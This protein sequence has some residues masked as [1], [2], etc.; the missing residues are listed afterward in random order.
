M[1]VTCLSRWKAD[2]EKEDGKTIF[3]LR[4]NGEL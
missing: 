1:A 4:S 3:P 2:R